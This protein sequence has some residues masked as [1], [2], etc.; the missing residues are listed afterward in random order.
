M[1][2]DLANGHQRLG[3]SALAQVFR[4]VG[5]ESPDVENADVLKAFFHAMAMLKQL[6]ANMPQAAPLVHAYHD[7]SDGGLQ[8]TLH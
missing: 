1:L 4:Q 2:I 5:T 6:H 7:R 3:G 8:T